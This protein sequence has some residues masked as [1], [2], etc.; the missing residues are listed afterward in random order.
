MRFGRYFIVGTLAFGVDLG[1]LLL[2]VQLLPLLVA[3]TVAFLVANLFNFL[4]AHVWV[5]R[6]PFRG[7]DLARQYVS[8]LAISLV[9]LALND[10]LVWVGVK[11]LEGDVVVSKVVATLVTLVWNYLSRT[12]WV[13]RETRA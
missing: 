6:R 13:Y 9:G 10:A 2:L 1:C 12:L 7:S 5:F 8:V 11:V 3:N 4:L